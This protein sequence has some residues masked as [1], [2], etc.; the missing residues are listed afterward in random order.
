MQHVFFFH[1]TPGSRHFFLPEWETRPNVRFHVLERPGIR[2]SNV[3]YDCDIGFGLSTVHHGRTI[4]SFVAD[5]LEY[6]DE[7]QIERFC[8]L[9]YSAGSPYAAAC[10]ARIASSR[11]TG[12]AIVSGVFDG[13]GVAKRLVE[14]DWSLKW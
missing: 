8:V 14:F 6:A 7:K 13:P 12:C 4:S 11:L 3:T 10:V 5:V 2:S 1:G 9:G